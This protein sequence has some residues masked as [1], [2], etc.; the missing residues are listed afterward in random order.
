MN[1]K[2]NSFIED[3]ALAFGC[4]FLSYSFAEI[5]D[6]P[7]FLS[8]CIFI[9]LYIFLL[10]NKQ[11]SKKKKQE[12]LLKQQLE[13][14]KKYLDKQKIIEIELK[15]KENQKLLEENQ[16]IE[17]EYE[18]HPNQISL[19][20]PKKYETDSKTKEKNETQK[21]KQQKSEIK[22]NKTEKREEPKKEEKVV[23]PMNKSS[24][25]VFEYDNE[26]EFRKLER[27]IKK[28]N[29]LAYKKLFFEYYPKLKEGNF[30]GKLISSNQKDKIEKF[31]LELPTEKMFR[32]VHDYIIL[33]YTV[34]KKEK[35]IF[36]N[37]ITPTDI[38]LEGHKDE[39]LQYKGVIV[40]KRHAEKDMF[41]INL[42]NSIRKD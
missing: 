6:L 36:L 10:S 2:D 16:K 35:V 24:L 26:N 13:I 7:K 21:N 11:K 34:Y 25:Y 3:L 12:E 37:T 31:E 4:L 18:P 1:N 33:D 17:K 32:K 14:K 39:L 30:L 5:F 20:D 42:L 23:I 28:Y 29:M 38:L 8:T 15:E 9:T 41:K 19:F 27:S 22:S 40:S